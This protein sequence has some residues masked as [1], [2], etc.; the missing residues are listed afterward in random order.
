MTEAPR[1]LLLTFSDR[2]TLSDPAVVVRGEGGRSYGV[3]VSKQS[4]AGGGDTVRAVPLAALPAGAY[5]IVYRVVGSDGDR[6]EGTVAFGIATPVSDVRTAGGGGADPRR[7]QP[8]TTLLR[9]LLFLGVALGLGGAYLARRVDSTTGG[10]PGVRPLLR[11]G[12]LLAL[13]GVLGLLVQLA[14][15]ARL[16]SMAT[17]P[18]VGRLL[19]VQ[20]LL[21]ALAALTARRPARGVLSA[22]LLL[23]V[24]AVEGARAHPREVSQLAGTAL[25]ATHLLAG[26]LWLGGLVHVL[27][28]VRSWRSRPNA[29]RVAVETYARN[30]LGL[31]VLVSVTGTASALMLLPAARD[32]TGTT[33]GRLLLLKLAVFAVAVVLAVFA[34]ARLRRTRPQEALASAQAGSPAG[35]W[36]APVPDRRPVGVVAAVEAA[37]LAAVV[38]AAA[39]VTTVTPARLV[40]ASSL[41]A[42]PIGPVVRVADRV[43]QVTVAVVASRGRVEIRTEAP[44]DGRPLRVRLAA[45]LAP[46]GGGE[47]RLDLD[48]CGS[49]CWTGPVAWGDGVNVLRVD[50]DA[51]RWEAG[52]LRIPVTWP[53]VPAPELVARV[54][55]AMGARSAID[56]VE[57]VTSGFGTVAPYRSRRTGQ[58]FL[59]AQPWS[60]G[61]VTDAAVVDDGGRRTLLFALPALGYHFA[62]RLD[63]ANRIVSERIVTPNHLLTREYSYPRTPR[64]TRSTGSPAPE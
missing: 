37:V 32:W 29:V 52:R 38:L 30:A 26:A 8:V 47:R 25:V 48:R 33:F 10:L 49:F 44:D 17:G 55:R 13:L 14:P 40:P 58:Q 6:I 45:G 18:G 31:F 63:A 39:A 57:R 9:T 22:L 62:L 60:K 46:P 34:R 1:E 61:G 3:R 36:A 64:Q 53:V 54:Q 28:L 23:G 20:A 4:G 42:A 50:V 21:L 35:P 24:V 7:P 16:P 56:T 2:V 5:Q 11:S 43:R 12:A 59:Q 15:P 51:D 19:G 27:R 41:L